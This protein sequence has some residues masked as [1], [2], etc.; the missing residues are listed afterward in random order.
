MMQETQ[1]QIDASLKDS[2]EAVYQKMGMTFSDA[3]RIFAIASLHDE[4]VP[5][6]IKVTAARA[7]SSRH[8]GGIGIAKGIFTAPDDIDEH[9]DE[10][11]QMFG[12]A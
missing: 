7:D 2:A 4:A 1:V 12:I 10:I 3:V 6:M 8:S 11:L 5:S 9:N